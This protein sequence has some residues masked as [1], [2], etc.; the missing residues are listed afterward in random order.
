MTERVVQHFVHCIETHGRHVQ[1]LR[2]LQTIVKCEGQY[3]RRS[4]DTAMAA[5]GEVS[6]GSHNRRLQRCCREND[7]LPMWLEDNFSH[8]VI[9]CFDKILEKKTTRSL[10]SSPFLKV[11]PTPTRLPNYQTWEL[12]NLKDVYCSKQVFLVPSNLIL[13][14]LNQSWL[15]LS[16]LSLGHI[17][18]STFYKHSSYLAQI[19]NGN[20]HF[21]CLSLLRGIQYPDFQV[22]SKENIGDLLKAPPSPTPVQPP[23]NFIQAWHK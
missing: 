2:F 20:L 18:S 11:L 13:I 7:K 21:C 9:V 14:I 5:M 3:L 4:Q 10:T 16:G 12:S 15:V 19:H 8:G 1:Y 17:Y 22:N 6:T 23:Y